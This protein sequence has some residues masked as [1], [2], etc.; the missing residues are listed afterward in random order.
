[1]RE[2]AIKARIPLDDEHGETLIAAVRS[3][4]VSDFHELNKEL[5]SLIEEGEKVI[6]SGTLRSDAMLKKHVNDL[7][8]SVALK[9]RHLKNAHDA[10]E[11]ELEPEVLELVNTRIKEWGT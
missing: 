1:M 2:L 11:I 7:K 9:C 3:Q 6:T 4:W 5:D 10:D 8:P